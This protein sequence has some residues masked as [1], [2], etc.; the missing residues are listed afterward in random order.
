[1]KKYIYILV[2][3]FLLTIGTTS[4]GEEYLDV[5]SPSQ[6]DEDFVFSTPDEAYKVL[7]GCYEIFRGRSYVHSNG[8]FY[9]LIIGGSD[10]ECHP[11]AYSAQQRHVPEGLYA[12]EDFSI[13]FNDFQTAWRYCYQMANRLAIV[14]AQIESKPAFQTA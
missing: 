12:D 14:I 2:S 5:S 13:D 11:E 1:M 9:D 10:S 3:V 6:V 8:L 7:M 4:C